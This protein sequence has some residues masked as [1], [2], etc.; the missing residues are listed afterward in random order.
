MIPLMKMLLN[1]QHGIPGH[2]RPLFFSTTSGRE[3]IVFTIPGEWAGAAGNGYYLLD[4][5]ERGARGDLW[6]LR[7]YR[8]MRT[9]W[10][11]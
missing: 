1:I 6:Y 4:R 10:G 9:C 2:T 8:T 7:M 5:L 3:A 11:L